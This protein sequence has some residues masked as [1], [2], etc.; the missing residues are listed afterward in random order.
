MKQNKFNS[1]FWLYKILPKKIVYCLELIRFEK[2]IGFLLLMWPCWFTLA[3]FSNNNIKLYILFFIGSFCMRSVGCIINDY[4]DQSIDKKVERTS[5]RPL[6]VGSLNLI[7]ISILIS[8]LLIISLIILMQFNFIAI[9]ISL[10]S[11]PLVI[12]YPLMKRFTYWPQLFLGLTFS[13][14]VLIASA[15]SIETISLQAILLYIG[16]VFWTLGY[17]TIYAYQDREDDIKID[18]KSTAILFSDSGKIF[19][20]LFYFLFILFIFISKNLY[21]FNL[22]NFLLLFFIL[23]LTLL[24]INKWSINSKLSSNNYFKKNN[25][26]GLMIFLYLLLLNNV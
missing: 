2:P 5:R 12:I 3:L 25:M 24:Y 20:M 26:F 7:D 18:L 6:A 21:E 15:Q 19:V 11:I 13:W 23:I 4:I 22:L 9:M 10:T 16:C 1:N 14:G 8:I 17:D